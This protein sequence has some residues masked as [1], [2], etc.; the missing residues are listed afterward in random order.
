M[1]LYAIRVC[2][3]FLFHLTKQPVHAKRLCMIFIVGFLLWM[4]ENICVGLFVS[5][6]VHY[7]MERPH[8]GNMPLCVGQSYGL[9]VYLKS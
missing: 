1:E 5:L 7:L 3:S 6:G 9:I 4:R 8:K 2:C